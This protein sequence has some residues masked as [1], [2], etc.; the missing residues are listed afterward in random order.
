LERTKKLS[1]GI[2]A[3]A[4][5]TSLGAATDRHL[6]ALSCASK[7]VAS[8]LAW[9][10]HQPTSTLQENHRVMQIRNKLLFL[11]AVAAISTFGL[12]GCMT[13]GPNYKAPVAD[14]KP[15]YSAKPLAARYGSVTSPGPAIDT[16]WPGF[17]D[18]K[19][20]KIV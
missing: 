20:T 3:M 16:W 4:T 15:F 11:L 6:D 17:N 13:V 1:G 9:E 14:I 10:E 2:L 8:E 12:G 19:L 7:F 5:S 18:P